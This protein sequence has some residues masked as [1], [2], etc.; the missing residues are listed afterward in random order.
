MLPD[1]SP[2]TQASPIGCTRRVGITPVQLSVPPGE[3]WTPR[4]KAARWRSGLPA[5]ASALLNSRPLSGPASPSRAP[6]RGSG[7]AAG[8]RLTCARPPA[9]G[10]ARAPAPAGRSH[11]R[12]RRPRG[13]RPGSA[14]PAAARPHSAWR[15]GAS[16]PPPRGSCSSLCGLGAPPASR[17]A[18]RAGRTRGHRQASAQKTAKGTGS[19]AESFESAPGRQ[20]ACFRGGACRW[21]VLPRIQRPARRDPRGGASPQAEPRSGRRARLP[22]GGRGGTS[23]ELRGQA[24][25]RHA[26]PPP[27]LP[28][29][30]R[31]HPQ[32]LASETV[33]F[34]ARAG[35]SDHHSA[36]IIFHLLRSTL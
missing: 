36:C 18:H 27:P 7:P 33:R 21:R 11:P 28:L 1:L 6:P 9:A 25:G 14:R 34:S 26:E 8:G 20:G 29:L 19:G 3:V 22:R 23:R 5:A 24:A 4:E 17:G 15:S 16:R 2:R 13:R 12:R 32:F 31:R 30:S 35:P 10:T